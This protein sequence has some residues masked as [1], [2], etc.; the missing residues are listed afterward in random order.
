MI[1]FPSTA[2]VA[3]TPRLQP[4]TL[5]VPGLLPRRPRLLVTVY[6]IAVHSV[7]SG[8]TA[9]DAEELGTIRTA[10]LTIAATLCSQIGAPEMRLLHGGRDARLTC[11]NL[12]QRH[13]GPL[14]AAIV[15][16]APLLTMLGREHHLTD[17]Y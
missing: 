10:T 16:R 12:A 15:V 7:L 14:A 2:T 8:G 17:T 4:R 1:L 13:P 6:G 11:Y 5:L 3:A 9:D